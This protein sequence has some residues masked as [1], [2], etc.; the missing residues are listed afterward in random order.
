MYHSED[1]S[2]IT[3]DVGAPLKSQSLTHS[4]FFCLGPPETSEQDGFF[5]SSGSTPGSS[6]SSP[7]MVDCTALIPLRTGIKNFQ[8]IVFKASIPVSSLLKLL[9]N[10]VKAFGSTI[11]NTIFKIIQDFL[12]PIH[13]RSP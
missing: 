9:T 6:G 11:C 4:G 3:G 13:E 5:G 1:F 10:I 7:L 8:P 12:L 2:S